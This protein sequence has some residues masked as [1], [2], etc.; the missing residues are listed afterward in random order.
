MFKLLKDRD[1]R[2][3]RIQVHGHNSQCFGVNSASPEPKKKKRWLFAA[4]DCWL[5]SETQKKKTVR[6]ENQQ[7]QKQQAAELNKFFCIALGN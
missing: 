2:H 3:H 4:C 1:F 5:F 7:L 6:E